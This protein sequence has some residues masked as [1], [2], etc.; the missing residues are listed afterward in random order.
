MI[1]EFYLAIGVALFVWCYLLDRNFPGYVRYSEAAQIIFF[2]LLAMAILNNKSRQPGTN[3]KE[4]YYE[5][6]R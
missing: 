5:W 1:I 3:I 6:I 4:K 2:L